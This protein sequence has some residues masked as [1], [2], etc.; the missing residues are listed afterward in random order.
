MTAK[1]APTHPV[2]FP[3]WTSHGWLATCRC[4]FGAALDLPAPGFKPGR[5][6]LAR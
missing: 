3:L 4:H 2:T 5:L 1:P 6:E